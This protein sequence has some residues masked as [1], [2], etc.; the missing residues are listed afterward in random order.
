MN[1]STSQLTSP[2]QNLDLEAQLGVLRKLLPYEL[3]PIR[4]LN[5]HFKGTVDNNQSSLYRAA[6]RNLQEISADELP[7]PARHSMM[8]R[9]IKEVPNHHLRQVIIEDH[10]YK[11][12]FQDAKWPRDLI[13]TLEDLG[14]PDLARD[15]FDLLKRES[16][17]PK[18]SRTLSEDDQH[19]LLQ[20]FIKRGDDRLKEDICA[21]VNL[22]NVK[23]ADYREALLEELAGSGND[24]VRSDI[25]KS[26]REMG[27]PRQS[28][29][30][31]LGKLID[32]GDKKVHKDILRDNLATVEGVGSGWFEILLSKLVDKGAADIRTE[33]SQNH[34]DK[35][36]DLGS[37]QY[38]R[39]KIAEREKKL[40][41]SP[42]QIKRDA[43]EKAGQSS[44][45][46]GPSTGRRF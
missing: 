40:G 18:E 39:S 45:G 22:Q 12:Q 41:S 25:Q 3:P 33:I 17:L 6:L 9:V 16:Q 8:L 37:R 28:Q 34:V 15:I 14:K 29:G 46:Q 23:R 32:S 2:L 13:F 20:K 36:S 43:L 26:I 31:V 21:Y 4:Q 5:R 30:F 38:V 35:L 42:A 1:P 10:A 44:F 11:G 24:I 19:C 27:L 7:D